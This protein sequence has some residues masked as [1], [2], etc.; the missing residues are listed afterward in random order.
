MNKTRKLFSLGAGIGSGIVLTIVGIGLAIV[1]VIAFLS[2]L[3]AFIQAISTPSLTQAGV[4][5][6]QMVIGVIA[7]YMSSKTLG[8]FRQVVSHQ[9]EER[10]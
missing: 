8:M 3:S 6:S 5:L 1:S 9:P 4:M 2:A 10:H 7:L